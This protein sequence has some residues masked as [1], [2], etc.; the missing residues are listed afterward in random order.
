MDEENI[1]MAEVQT[2]MMDLLVKYQGSFDQAVA[3]CFKLILDCY[4]L[5][6]GEEDTQKLLEHAV[7]SVK[8]GNHSQLF[9]NLPKM[10]LTHIYNFLSKYTALHKK[11]L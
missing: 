11:S 6:M 1:I 3:M 4:V 2:D 10:Y 5:Q 7:K 8:M 9:E